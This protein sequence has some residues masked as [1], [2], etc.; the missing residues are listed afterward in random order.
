MLLSSGSK[1]AVPEIPV[2]VSLEEAF[3]S[4][5]LHLFHRITESPRLEKTSEII[6]AAKLLGHYRLPNSCRLL[7]FK[8]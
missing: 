6:L 3:P 5:N 8:N 1:T 2:S 4:T 7:Y